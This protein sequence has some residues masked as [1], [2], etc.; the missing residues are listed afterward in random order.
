V[1][2]RIEVAGSFKSYLRYPEWRPHNQEIRMKYKC[3]DQM[4]YGLKTNLTGNISA[5][6]SLQI[7]KCNSIK[8]FIVEQLN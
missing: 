2:N 3:S 6:L 7:G 8:V 4:S 5:E 1:T